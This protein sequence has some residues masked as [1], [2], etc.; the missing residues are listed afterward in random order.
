MLDSI[1]KSLAIELTLNPT[2]IEHA[3]SL[4]RLEGTGSRHVQ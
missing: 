3:I 1:A 4:I 2:A